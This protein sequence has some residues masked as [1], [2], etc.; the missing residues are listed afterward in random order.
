[1][2]PVQR[3]PGPATGGFDYYVLMP[4]DIEPTKKLDLR[5]IYRD[6][7]SNQELA[8]ADDRPVLAS[9]GYD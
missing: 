2:A 4:E 3:D 8:T 5:V 1:M 6:P 7:I 9:R